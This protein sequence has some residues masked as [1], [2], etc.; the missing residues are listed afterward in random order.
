LRINKRDGSQNQHPDKDY[1]KEQ[2]SGTRNAAGAGAASFKVISST[3]AFKSQQ[4]ESEK[5]FAEQDAMKPWQICMGICQ[6]NLSIMRRNIPQLTTALSGAT[7][8]IKAM[9]AAAVAFATLNFLTGGKIIPSTSPVPPG[10]L[11]TGGSGA[12]GWGEIARCRYVS[13]SNCNIHHPRRR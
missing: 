13:N 6:P 2:Q 10:K 9:T 3:N 4:L 7:T 11:P 5:V 8:G 1:I 12:W